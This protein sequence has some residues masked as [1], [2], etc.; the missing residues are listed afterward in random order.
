[1][2]ID[3]F[4]IQGRLVRNIVEGTLAAGIHDVTIDGRGSHGE[5]LPSG[6]Y[7]IQGISS[8]GEFKQVITI[9]K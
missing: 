4:D 3:L 8:D 9:L 1:V 6:V 5:K 7:Y 2:R